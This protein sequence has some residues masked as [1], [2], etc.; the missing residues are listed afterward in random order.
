M[1]SAAKAWGMS[2]TTAARRINIAP[3][4]CGAVE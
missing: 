3:K 4:T 1:R 2:K